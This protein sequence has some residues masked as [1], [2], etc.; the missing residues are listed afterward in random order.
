MYPT[1]HLIFVALT[2]FQMQALRN[3][4]YGQYSAAGSN[5]AQ[6][7]LV[8]RRLVLKQKLDPSESAPNLL[9]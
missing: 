9:P 5:I 7:S 6:Y 2:H 8:V 1:S 3:T 4:A